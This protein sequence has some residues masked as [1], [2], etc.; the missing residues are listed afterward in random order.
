MKEE[1][2]RGS[3]EGRN[4]DDDENKLR[5]KKADKKES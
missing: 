1:N 2:K 5:A 4:E 3:R